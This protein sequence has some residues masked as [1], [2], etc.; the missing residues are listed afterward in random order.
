[1]L[2]FADASTQ[3]PQEQVEHIMERAALAAGRRQAA[4][5]RGG[6]LSRGIIFEGIAFV[7]R[8]ASA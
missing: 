6:H 5:A 7:S 1:M 4:R 8:P 3:S 2:G